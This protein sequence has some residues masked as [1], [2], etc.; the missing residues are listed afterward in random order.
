[1]GLV[2]G[3]ACPPIHVNAI[4]VS[5]LAPIM[6]GA[7]VTI[8]ARFAPDTLLGAIERHL[9]L[10]RADHLRAARRAARARVAGHLVG[11]VRGV[12]RGSGVQGAAAALPN[13]PIPTRVTWSRDATATH[14]T[15]LSPYSVGIPGMYIC[16]AATPP[17]PGAHGM[18]GANAAQAALHHLNHGARARSSAALI[19]A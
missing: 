2:R 13:G 5:C 4:L 18:C 19:N 12:R 16:S 9:L 7:Q 15:S 3:G 11:A 6:V 1:M 10:R 17:G 8:L 14:A